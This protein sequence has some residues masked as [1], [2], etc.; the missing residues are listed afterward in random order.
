MRNAFFT[1][2]CF[3]F[4][5]ATL[6]P[7]YA[8]ASEADLERVAEILSTQRSTLASVR[9]YE[10]EASG[11]RTRSPKGPKLYKQ[12]VTGTVLVV[13][14][15]GVGSGVRVGKGL[16]VTNWHVVQGHEYAA[17]LFWRPQ[18]ANLRSLDALDVK[19]WVI[20]L[21]LDR[22]PKRDLAL[23]AVDPDDVPSNATIIKSGRLPDVFVG[24]D[25]Y[26]IGHPQRLFWS[27]TEG[28]VSQI[29]R[30]Y[31]WKTKLGKHQ[32]TIIQTQTPISFGSSGGPL[33]DQR[34]RLVGLNTVGLA[35]G[36]YFA[37]AV[38]EVNTFIFN[39]LARLRK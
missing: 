22:D 36:L 6:L 20:A 31:V 29:R 4:L 38:N 23:L 34:G 24:Q 7:F 19:D 5:V 10:P 26:A 35:A 39:A 15:S 18:L 14:E 2:L 3:F 17:I 30:N 25:V 9:V 37:V 32:A 27:Y 12:T 1:S 16:I 13:T 33:F 8:L 11:L 21:V 28:V